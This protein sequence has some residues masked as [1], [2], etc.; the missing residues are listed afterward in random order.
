MSDTNRVE[1]SYGIESTY[2][3]PAGTGKRLR[4]TSDGLKDN[5]TVVTSNEIRADRQ[6]AGMSRVDRNASGALGFELSYGAHDDLLELAVQ[7]AG[8]ST[9]VSVTADTIAHVGA[10]SK[11]TDSGNG[12][13]SFGVGWAKVIGNTESGNSGIFKIVAA[14]AGELTFEGV[15][16]TDEAAGK[17]VTVIYLGQLLNGVDQRTLSLQKKFT[18]L[19]NIFDVGR[20]LGLNTLSLS[21]QVGSIMSGSMSFYGKNLTPES[22]AIYGSPTAA[23]NN[24]VMNAVDNITLLQLDG[25]TIDLTEFTININNNMRGRPQLRELG[26]VSLGSGEFNVDLTLKAYNSDNALSSKFSDFQPFSFAVVVQDGA[27][28]AYVFDLPTVYPSDNDR[29]APSKNQDV[30]VMLSGSCVVDTDEGQMM[31]IARSP[32][33]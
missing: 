13:G 12:F 1:F 33:A 18:D 11:I 9:P 17:D 6:V 30:F 14:S 29:P 16:F 27:G 4:V 3:T 2:A 26:P 31:R 32:A 10:T 21:A 24:G 7:S 19:S 22:T 25:S 5:A 15:D 23:P 8:W 20:G 28:N